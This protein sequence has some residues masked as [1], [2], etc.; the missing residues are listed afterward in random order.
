MLNYQGVEKLLSE[1]KLTI[2]KLQKPVAFSVSMFCIPLARIVSRTI[3]SSCFSLRSRIASLGKPAAK[4]GN[5]GN[6]NVQLRSCL[7]SGL[8]MVYGRYNY[9]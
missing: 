9:S 2:S 3:S 1:S 5:A 7:I 4:P 8:T 6:F